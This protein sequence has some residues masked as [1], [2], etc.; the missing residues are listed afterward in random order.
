MVA[1]P[2]GPEVVPFWDNPYRILKISHNKE[3]LRGLWV[4]HNL[5]EVSFVAVP[6]L[7]AFQF[8]GLFLF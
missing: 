8:S 6:Q 3:L 5:S 7:Q 1:L 4:S 2:I